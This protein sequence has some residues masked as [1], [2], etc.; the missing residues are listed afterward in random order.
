ML[1]FY[2]LESTRDLMTLFFHVLVTVRS[3]V[4]SVLTLNL[5]ILLVAGNIK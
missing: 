3:L 1:L 4:V 5:P 2:R